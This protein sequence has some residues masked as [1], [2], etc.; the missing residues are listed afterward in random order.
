MTDDAK[1]VYTCTNAEPS[2]RRAS[3]TSSS[4]YPF[5]PLSV[6]PWMICFEAMKYTMVIGSIEISDAA[7][8]R[9][10]RVLP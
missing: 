2:A 10:K 6:T 1:C 9:L 7:I 4:I 5:T 8:C 3:V